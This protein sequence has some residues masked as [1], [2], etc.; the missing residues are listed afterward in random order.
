MRA[1]RSNQ[2]E[3]ILQFRI[4]PYCKQSL[5][6]LQRKERLKLSED[7]PVTFLAMFS[8]LKAR[9][10]FQDQKNKIFDYSMFNFR[11]GG[12]SHLFILPISPR[13]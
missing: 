11:R 9:D 2:K 12:G 4:I 10:K 5:C 8:A 3:K 6:S 7:F 13:F 1:T